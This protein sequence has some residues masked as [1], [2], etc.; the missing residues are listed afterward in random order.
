MGSLIYALER[1][2]ERGLLSK[3]QVF[4]VGQKPKEV[5]TNE[6]L[7]IAVGQC[8]S[9]VGKADILIQECPPSASQIIKR[10]YSRI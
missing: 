3:Q 2:Y 4:L 9:K 5:K 10:V 1:L 8:A 7:S 6:L